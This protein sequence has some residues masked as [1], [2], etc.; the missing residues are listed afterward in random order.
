MSGPIRK[1]IGPAKTRLLRYIAE[2][3]K[4]LS[5]PIQT[6]TIED[7]KIN[8]EDLIEHMNNDVSILER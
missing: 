6:E 7:D 3:E 4:L 1:L 2:A 5:S 8:T